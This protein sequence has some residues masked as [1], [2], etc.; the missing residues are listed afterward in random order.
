MTSPP[1]RKL[2]LVDDSAADGALLRRF[3]RGT[4][5]RVVQCHH[6]DEMLDTVRGFAP[7][8]VLLDY[9]L[10]GSLGWE[11]LEEARRAY[12]T[13][14]LAIAVWSGHGDEAVAAEA[15]RLGAQDYLVKSEL[16]T[17]SCRRALARLVSGTVQARELA[18]RDRAVLRANHEL[19]RSNEALH[20]AIRER[21]VL[22]SQVGHDMRGPLTGLAAVVEDLEQALDTEA[23]ELARSTLD[24]LLVMSRDLQA[25]GG[26]EAEPAPSHGQPVELVALAQ[27][28]LREAASQP[29]VRSRGLR[30][31]VDAPATSLPFP[32]DL[33]ILTRILGNTC[34]SACVSARTTVEVSVRPP[35]G[36][37]RM[38]VL[39]VDDDGPAPPATHRDSSD[40]FAALRGH[41]RPATAALG[42]AY[43]HRAVTR[44]GG[45]VRVS[46]SP[47][48][49]ARVTL[50]LPPLPARTPDEGPAT[51]GSG[52]EA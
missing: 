4:P 39:R 5:W 51:S 17:V 30:T 18:L 27:R 26:L 13:E 38:L 21:A 16:G 11:H 36:A 29:A 44:L 45:G 43:V 41:D 34:E 46:A 25:L 35:A 40:A 2:V 15:M 19:E 24:R 14:V 9:R 3:L 37:E 50:A 52:D 48:G 47:L 22:L 7:D 28:V 12:P 42:L 8:V 20:E 1:E 32:A 6:L 49:G 10:P 31:R 23:A 33:A